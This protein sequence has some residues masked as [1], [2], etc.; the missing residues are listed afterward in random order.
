MDLAALF[1]FCVVLDFT[2]PRV[3]TL[4]GLAQYHR[5]PHLTRPSGSCQLVPQVGAQ[6]LSA[7]PKSSSR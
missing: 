5:S 3:C 7:V 6:G 2:Q 4:G 1:L